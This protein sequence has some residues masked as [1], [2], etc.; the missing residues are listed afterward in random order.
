MAKLSKYIRQEKIEFNGA[1]LVC[2]FN[3]SNIYVAKCFIIISFK[4]FIL[5]LKYLLK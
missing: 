5:A 2:K 4:T 3:I 1:N